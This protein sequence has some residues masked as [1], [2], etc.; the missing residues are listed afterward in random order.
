[1]TPVL[2]RA[3]GRWGLAALV[4]NGVIGS[5]VFGL[6][7][8]ITG[9]LGAASPW[10]WL[11]AACGIAVI[12]A[13]FAEVASRF[14]DA[15]GPYLYA[16]AAFGPLAGIQ[17]AWFAY[18]TRLTASAT[19]ANLFVIYLGEFWP[20]A[21]GPLANRLVLAAV[22]VPLA[23]LNYRGVQHGSRLSGVLIVLKL[24][25]LLFFVLAGL[26]LVVPHPAAP[27]ATVSPHLRDWLDVILLLVFAYGG[28]EAALVP[29]AEAKQPRR[30]APFAL[31]LT[32]AVCAVLYCT[33]QIV[34][35]AALPD[36]ASATRPLAAAAEVFLGPAGAT[37]L[38]LAAMVSV[39][40]Y[41][42]GA[43]VN[44]PRLTYAMAERGDLPDPL[45]R[46]HSRFKTPYVSVVLF[47]VL[48]WLLAASSGFLQNLSLSA[49][50]RLFT[51][52]MVCAALPLFRAR[53]RSSE[54]SVQP[55]SFVLPAGHVWAFL[56]IGFSLL[57]A[58][59]MTEKELLVLVVTIALGLVNWRWTKRRR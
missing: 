59:R 39:Y 23:L 20:G 16:H 31:F 3:I 48:V 32:L 57:V 56:G 46:V 27:T 40:G 37:L 33:V 38:A 6:P 51:Y 47:A 14:D 13:C 5:S 24:L 2:I 17:M 52:G 8:V 35:N 43:M 45:G 36:P 29:L 55:A 50:S 21:T 19:N 49:V 41:L 4:L 7:S 15:G 22:I 26:A 10:A 9:R 44:V 28:F 54:S 30:D 42:A 53:D 34:V 1:M 25:P 11:I 12:I 18:L 58:T